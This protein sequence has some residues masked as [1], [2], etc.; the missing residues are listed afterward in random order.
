MP[1]SRGI[2]F[3]FHHISLYRNY[4]GNRCQTQNYESYSPFL[5]KKILG[6]K[7]PWGYVGGCY[8]E[9]LEEKKKKIK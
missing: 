2:A 5:A 4:I 7:T 6:R 1:T 8:E 3:S 9:F